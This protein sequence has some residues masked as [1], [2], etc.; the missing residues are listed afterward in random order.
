MTLKL[1]M[2]LNLRRRW[3]PFLKL[4]AMPLNMIHSG[5]SYWLA[6]EAVQLWKLV[7]I[8][9]LMETT[10]VMMWY[11]MK[12]AIGNMILLLRHNFFSYFCR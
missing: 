10:V 5:A 8:D 7:L 12:L 1:P 2:T 11:A 3:A 4:G 9:C 6:T